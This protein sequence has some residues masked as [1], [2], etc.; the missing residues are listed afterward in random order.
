MEALTLV[1]SPL[2]MPQCLISRYGVTG[3]T[4]FPDAT[5]L[6]TKSGSTPSTAATVFIS[7][8]IIPLFASSIMLIYDAP[9]W[10]FV[11]CFLTLLT[12]I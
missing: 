12:H 6:R 7:S 4:I 11:G 5:P 2:P 9:I 10:I 8:V 3:I 1:V